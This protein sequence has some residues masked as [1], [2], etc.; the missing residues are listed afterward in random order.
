MDLNDTHDPSR[1]SFVPGANTAETDFPIQNLPFGAMRTG[2]DTHCAVAIGDHVLDL[3]RAQAAGLLAQPALAAPGLNALMAL[4]FEAAGDLRGRLSTLLAEGSP[5]QAVLGEMLTPLSAATL[6]LPA[7]I[8]SF[9]DFFTSL[10]HTER[11]GKLSGRNPPVPPSFRTLPIAY[12]SRATSVRVSG[13]PV[14]RP[15][16][17]RRGPDGQVTFGP[18][19]ALDFELEL[20]AFV[21]PGNALGQPLH[22]D[23]AAQQLWGYCLLNDWSSRDVQGYESDPLGPF[24]CKSFS[25]TISPWIVTAEA[26]A[27]FRIPAPARPGGDPAPLPYLLSDRDQSKGGIS[28]QMRALLLTPAMRAAGHPPATITQTDFRDIYWTFAQMATHHMSNGCNLRPGDLL[29]SGTVS[30][31]TDDSRAC[32]AEITSRGTDP[33]TLPGGEHRGWLMDGDEIMFRARAEREGFVPIGFGRCDG[34]V[35]PA[36]AWPAGVRA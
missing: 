4:G 3:H 7:T 26:L 24:L 13:E 2:G 28:L 1:R 34:V 36:V 23:A 14:T 33:L 35:S 20:A 32:L 19:T 6:V 17:Q 16:G 18:S 27:P 22:I 5:S 9:T 11:G 12:N 31:P 30:G 21:G 15:L 29:G 25:T 8:G 10:Y